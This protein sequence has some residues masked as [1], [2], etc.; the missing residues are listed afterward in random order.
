MTADW[1]TLFAPVVIALVPII[2][3]GT[4]KYIPPSLTWLTPILAMVLGPIAD[5]IS[6]KATGVG[7]GTAAAAALG[8]AGVGLREIVNQLTKAMTPA[9]PTP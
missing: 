5:M 4:K 3:A 9:P 1:Q 2:V 6:Q 8:L 7:V